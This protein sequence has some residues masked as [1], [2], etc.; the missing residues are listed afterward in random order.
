MRNVSFQAWGATKKGKFLILGELSETRPFRKA[1][2]SEAI[3]VMLSASGAPKFGVENGVLRG[4]SAAT[5]QR[6]ILS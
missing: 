3:L 6:R 1:L 5:L 2:S 4:L